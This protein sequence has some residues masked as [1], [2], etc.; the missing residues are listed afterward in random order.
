VQ[1]LTEGDVPYYLRAMPPSG[2][3]LAMNATPSPSLVAAMAAACAVL[4]H[5]AKDVWIGDENGQRIADSAAIKKHYGLDV[6][7]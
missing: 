1:R 2:R 4:R 6:T 5:G 7:K 3:L